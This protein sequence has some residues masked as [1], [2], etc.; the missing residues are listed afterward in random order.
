MCGMYVYVWSVCMYVCV[1]T[2]RM[3]VG[4]LHTV[5]MYMCACVVCVCTY[6]MCVC[7]YIYGVNML[8]V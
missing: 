4:V 8:Y 3:C 7:T 5:C 2:I 1:R 6:M